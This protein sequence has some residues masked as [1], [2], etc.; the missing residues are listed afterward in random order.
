MFQMAWHGAGSS[1]HVGPPG[2][3]R[4][5]AAGLAVS[6][7]QKKPEAAACRA[8]HP[9]QQPGLLPPHHGLLRLQE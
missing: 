4:P 7:S 2:R 6:D 9:Q 1:Q 3:R 5:E 8:P